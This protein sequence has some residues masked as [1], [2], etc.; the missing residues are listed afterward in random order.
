MGS[1]HVSQSRSAIAHARV[2]RSLDEVER[3]Q[4]RDGGVQEDGH[5]QEDGWI[6]KKR[7]RGE[8]TTCDDASKRPTCGAES[9]MQEERKAGTHPCTKE[10]ETCRSMRSETEEVERTSTSGLDLPLDVDRWTKG[11]QTIHLGLPSDAK[12][13]AWQA[14]CL[15]IPGVLEGRTNLVFAA[16]TSSGKSLVADIVLARRLEEC[17]G[18]EFCLLVLPFVSICHEKEECLKNMFRSPRKGIL[19]LYGTN[20]KRF[21]P[22]ESID[23]VV[24]TIEKANSLVGQLIE[25]EQLST[26]RCVVVDELH[27][28]SDPERGYVLEMMLTKLLYAK[29]RDIALTYQL[30]GMSA[31]LS[32]VS[33]VSKWLNA[34]VYETSFRPVK[35][36][37]MVKIGNKIY[38]ESGN[39][40]QEIPR[41]GLRSDDP[42]DLAYLCREVLEAKGNALVFCPSKQSCER[43]ASF[44]AQELLAL[45][46]LDLKSRGRI[47]QAI[48]ELP[49]RI[50][51]RLDA[52]MRK[53]VAYHHA[54][55]SKEERELIEHLYKASCVRVLCATSTLA[56]GVN[57]PT[58]R[59]IFRQPYV[60]LPTLHLDASRYRQ[61]SGRAG[62]TGLD[63]VGESI[64]L[65]TNYTTPDKL[66]SLLNEECT[67]VRSCLTQGKHGIAQT[68]LEA[69]ASGKVSEPQEVEDYLHSTLYA[70][71]VERSSILQ[72]CQSALQWLREKQ[73][74]AWI[75]PGQWKPT[76]FGKAAFA[77]SLSPDAAI[78]LMKELLHSRSALVLTADLHLLYLISPEDDDS[79]IDWQNLHERI[80]RLTD[81]E[82]QVINL[83][84]I[85]WNFLERCTM[86]GN[87]LRPNRRTQEQM[88]SCR[89]LLH[90]IMLNDL[91]N[92]VPLEM[93][94]A[95]ARRSKGLLQALQEKACTRA[96]R[97]EAFCENLAWGDLAKLVA[98]IRNR[99]ALGVKADIIALAEIPYVKGFRARVLH[100]AGIRTPE[101]IVGLGS[102][103]F[104]AQKLIEA[105]QCQDDIVIKRERRAAKMILEGA[106]D[107][108]ESRLQHALSLALEAASDGRKALGEQTM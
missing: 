67:P 3:M 85:E 20:G 105:S 73:F 52:L 5:V 75:K 89:R 24:A 69:I 99:I 66:F 92:E 48:Q 7:S 19:G 21:S 62:R 17:H 55:L 71:T 39:L 96:A 42:D 4:G 64:L 18:K 54:G 108:V 100:N 49:L 97:V 106:K 101:A 77:A 82:K 28:V 38:G 10:E 104:I 6:R 36:L 53:G 103:D 14:E 83:V 22:Q 43:C 46:H 63:M 57:L 44:L 8:P 95:S 16:P 15:S 9:K 72:E 76:G 32:S 37:H 90:A 93:A 56:A 65:C 102:V 68:L 41:M 47:E 70:A 98:V 74:V 59:V 94:A 2:L 25:Q 35:L 27:M 23:V 33:V 29:K 31:T 26:L 12:L 91:I 1:R 88:N 13:H 34:Q 60:G 80:Y 61:M 58:R 86:L 84:G 50:D 30:V 79:P 40:L 81:D 107:L 78:F 87:P 51:E 45:Q 11:L